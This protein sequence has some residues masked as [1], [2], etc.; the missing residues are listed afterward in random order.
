[1]LSPLPQVQAFAL[2]HSAGYDLQ[3]IE[4]EEDKATPTIVT[5]EKGFMDPRDW[6]FERDEDRLPVERGRLQPSWYVMAWDVRNRMAHH[7]P[8]DFSAVTAR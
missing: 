8:S 5:T 4:P 2:A 6:R 1:L 3:P 7:H